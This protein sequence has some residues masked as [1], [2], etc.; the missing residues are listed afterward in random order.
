MS[1]LLDQGDETLYQELTSGSLYNKEFEPY[2]EYD[3]AIMEAI[4]N[5]ER[6]QKKEPS[7]DDDI[8]F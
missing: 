2:Y 1:Q 8:P 4:K 6:R 5:Y 3:D 7:N